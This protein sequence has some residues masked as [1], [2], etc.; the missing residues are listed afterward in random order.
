M[1]VQPA[2]FVLQALRALPA[3]RLRALTW[4]S[5]ARFCFESSV[6]AVSTRVTSTGLGD[7]AAAGAASPSKTAVTAMATRLVISSKIGRRRRGLSA[8]P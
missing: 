5:A 8:W 1:R 3:A 2:P 7:C 4:P 6:M